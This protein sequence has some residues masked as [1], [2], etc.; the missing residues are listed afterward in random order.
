MH[1]VYQVSHIEF[2]FGKRRKGWEGREM[3]DNGWAMGAKV[4]PS[5][6]AVSMPPGTATLPPQSFDAAQTA[7]LRIPKPTK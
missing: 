6:P 1:P 2:Q 7:P 3:E 5:I 4:H